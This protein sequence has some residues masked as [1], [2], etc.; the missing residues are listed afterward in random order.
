MC[1]PICITGVIGP[2]YSSEAVAV[3]RVLTLLSA[4]NGDDRLPQVGFS[5]TAA[6]LRDKEEYPNFIS[7]VPDDGVQTEVSRLAFPLKCSVTSI[8]YR[9]STTEALTVLTLIQ[10]AL[11]PV[12][13]RFAAGSVS[14]KS[15]V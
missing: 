1:L 7:V 13:V 5:A 12:S 9:Y 6:S 4:V 11:L 2:E 14:V 8:K 3:S 10:L 15:G